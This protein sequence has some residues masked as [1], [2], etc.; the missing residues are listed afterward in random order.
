MNKFEIDRRKFLRNSLYSSVLFGVSGLP[1]IATKAHAGF[2]D[3]QNRLLVNVNLEGGPDFRHFIVPA[4]P[5]TLNATTRAT[6]AYKYWLHR[7]RTQALANS[8]QAWIDRWNNEYHHI[9]INDGGVN[10]NVTFGIWKGAGWLIKM[11]EAGNVAFIANTAIGRTRA[12][13]RSQVQLSQGDVFAVETET[14]RSGWGGRLARFTGDNSVSLTFSPSPFCF[15]PVDTP[16]YNPGAI[17]NRSYISIT[18]SRNLGLY[19]ADVDTNQTYNLN[20]KIARS[21]KSYYGALQLERS[22]NELSQ[23]YAKTLDHEQKVRFFGDQINAQINFSVPP[24]IEAL[25]SGVAGINLGAD[26]SPRRVL[27][28]SSFGRQIRNLYDAIAL[29]DTLSMRVASLYYGGWDSHAAQGDNS[30]NNDVY[31]PDVSRGIE[32]KFRDIFGGPL[33]AAST[34]LHGSLSALWESLDNANKDEMV[35]TVAGEFGRQIRQNGSDLAGTDHG[36]GNIVMVIGNSVTGGVYGDLFPESD[37]AGYDADER[38]TP[39]ITS[40]TDMDHVFGKVCDWVSSSS[41]ASIV[42]SN[43]VFP[44]LLESVGSENHPKLEAGVSLDNLMV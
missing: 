28:S 40:L 32:S 38:R 14:Q 26:N 29:N 19:S 44:R 42:S 1:N 2:T 13:D 35:I 6:Q 20:N 7:Y 30:G 37:L 43:R 36:D 25:Y 33:N 16:S 34:D 4:M 5:T 22:A 17:D 31:N 10:N 3:L 12:H 23:A 15:G 24:L 21:L 41:S 11:Y 9:T 18:N 27:E 8:E 39:D